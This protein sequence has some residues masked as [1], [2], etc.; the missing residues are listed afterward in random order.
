MRSHLPPLYSYPQKTT[1]PTLRNRSDPKAREHSLFMLLLTNRS[2]R[3]NFSLSK[4]HLL[5]TSSD[6]AS[7]S[8]WGLGRST[9][10][11]GS[12]GPNPAG[13]E[14]RVAFSIEGDGCHLGNGRRLFGNTPR[15]VS[16]TNLP[17]TGKWL[18]PWFAFEANPERKDFVCL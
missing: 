10:T 5:V 17:G 15:G 2:P 8:H 18:A 14:V 1:C 12:P 4:H 16:Q 6:D 9:S 3:F 13:P 7:T 11:L